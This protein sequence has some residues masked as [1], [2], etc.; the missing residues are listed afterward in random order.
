VQIAGALGAVHAKG[1]V[2]PDIKPANIFITTR[3]Q[4]KILEFGLAK[5]TL[6]CGISGQ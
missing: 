1:I 2:H 6:A 4:A 5:L 3:G